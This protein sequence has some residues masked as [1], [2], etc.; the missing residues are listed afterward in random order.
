[1]TAP[2]LI[3][4][5]AQLAA[6]GVSV[7][8]KGPATELRIAWLQYVETLRTQK[9]ILVPANID[10]N[11]LLGGIDLASSLNRG[12]KVI[13]SGLLKHSDSST[14]AQQ[15]NPNFLV[16]QM[17]ERWDRGLAA[18]F[19]L[20]L[21]SVS[22]ATIIAFDESLPNSDEAMLTVLS[23]RFPICIN[24]HGATFADYNEFTSLVKHTL[25]KHILVKQTSG[26]Q[27]T[28]HLAT[29]KLQSVATH[30][31]QANQAAAVAVSSEQI[32]Q[33]V[34]TAAVLGIDSSRLVLNTLKT[35]RA[36]AF[37]DHRPSLDDPD[38]QIALTLC[39]LPRATRLPAAP[40]SPDTAD[41][42]QID[43]APND[44]HKETQGKEHGEEAQDEQPD[45]HEAL[46]SDAQSTTEPLDPNEAS[47]ASESESEN[48]NPNEIAELVLEAALATLPNDV[49]ERLAK[50]G[51]ITKAQAGRSGQII[52]R[53]K[54]GKPI[55]ATRKPSFSGA[56][57]DLLSTIY[58]SLPW[59][60]IRQQQNS[61]KNKHGTVK[62]SLDT[63]RLHIEARDFRYAKY[64][65]KSESLLIF[66][67]DASGSAAMNRLAE[68]KGAIELLLAQSYARRDRVAMV[69]FRGQQAQIVL[70][71]T[72]S[73]TRAKR[74]LAG[75]PGGGAT[76]IAAGIEA[77][78][79][80][81]LRGR[82]AGLT[83]YVI[84]LSDGKANI[85]ASGEPGRPIAHQEALNSA[86][87]LSSDSIASLF[88]DTSP[89]V[90]PAQNL[91]LEIAQN[92]AAVYLA[93]PYANSAKL[94]HTIGKQVADQANGLSGT[95]N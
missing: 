23:D 57:P 91:A 35:M 84:V 65:Q 89:M 9:A 44:Q 12:R 52:R 70:E 67:V 64:Q 77:S 61:E 86:Q 5:A 15:P 88:I 36:H 49:L 34:Q 71:P 87:K 94:A 79:Q 68:T 28:A 76:P 20:A 3:L 66:T 56:R 58:A 46:S 24:L 37:I 30:D 39:L 78:W 54:R 33:L 25:V 47:H 63:R 69:A 17:A 11:G 32:I 43:S 82:Q 1:M 74:S 83:P 90:S 14:L 80:L 45:D 59:Q 81:A 40:D 31:E 4:S 18:E 27:A 73:L 10:R 16:L 62:T 48:L 72:R 92:M 41:Q 51:K 21:D 42:N 19:A 29:A 50:V 75:L 55:G 26:D 95:R 8:I 7:W 22:Q 53:A 38:Y 6:Q 2:Q 85:T 93:L 60:A 13:S